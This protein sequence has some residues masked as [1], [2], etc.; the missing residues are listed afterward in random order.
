MGLGLR[1]FRGFGCL[2]GLG[3]GVRDL[4]GLGVVLRPL[5]L[6]LKGMRTIMFQ[7][8]GFYD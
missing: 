2:R 4:G 6:D 8:S 1:G 5:V 7:L 3:F